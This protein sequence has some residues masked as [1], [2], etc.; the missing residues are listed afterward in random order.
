MDFIILDPDT[1]TEAELIEATKQNC[2]TAKVTKD[3]IEKLKSIARKEEKNK[4]KRTITSS[5]I[6]PEKEKLEEPINLN[7]DEVFED[8]IDYY[9]SALDKLTGENLLEEFSS[10][11]PSRK[12]YRYKEILYRL[13]A[14]IIRN[15]K[16]IKDCIGE[17]GI[18]E[19]VAKEFK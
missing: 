11:L 14:G 17:E 10:I 4:G 9:F 7:I 18:T 2:R 16:E 6:L 8:E 15:I 12:N 5:V 19:E 13:K 1:A 3:E